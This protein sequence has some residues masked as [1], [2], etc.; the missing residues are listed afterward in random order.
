MRRRAIPALVPLGLACAPVGAAAQDFPRVAEAASRR[1]LLNVVGARRYLGFEVYRAALY[2][3]RP[4]GDAAAILASAGVKLIRVRYA[5]DVGLDSVTAAW[6]E[7]FAAACG[8]GC[9]VPE[10]LR[11]WLRPI[12]AGD[13]VTYSFLPDA[14]ELSANSAAPARVPGAAA[15]RALLATWIG[16]HPPTAALKRGLLGGG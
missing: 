12:A 5:R 15:S 11:R 3:E 13:E 8:G 6:E 10:P 9:P 14:A 4:S 2:L 1:L 16:A 7:A